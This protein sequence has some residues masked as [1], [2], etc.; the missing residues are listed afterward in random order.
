MSAYGQNPDITWPGVEAR[1]VTCADPSTRGHSLGLFAHLGKFFVA[2]S[3]PLGDSWA[4]GV[5]IG[6]NA[7]A[8]Q[9]PSLDQSLSAQLANAS[10]IDAGNNVSAYHGPGY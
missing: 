2:K 10:F 5:C 6:A 8:W 9:S 1:Q 7:F 3:D 4:T